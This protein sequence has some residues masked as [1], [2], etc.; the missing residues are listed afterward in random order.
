MASVPGLPQLRGAWLSEGQPGSGALRYDVQ[1]RLPVG[2]ADD[3]Q[4]THGPAESAGLHQVHPRGSGAHPNTWH[5]KRNRKRFFFF[6]TGCRE[7]DFS[8][9]ST[10]LL[11]PVETS[12]SAKL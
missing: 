1:R 8:C 9:S 10:F 4:Q 5:S 7:S 3:P 2:A 12:S 6:P 11:P